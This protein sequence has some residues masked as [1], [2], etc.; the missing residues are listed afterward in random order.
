MPLPT[1]PTWNLADFNAATIGS[2]LALDGTLVSI[3]P[4]AF[5]YFSYNALYTEVRVASSDGVLATLDITTPVPAQYTVEIT[6]RFRDMPHNFGDLERRRIGLTVADDDGRGISIYFSKSGV[7]VARIDDFGSV[8]A[9][10]DTADTT[11]EISSAFRTIRIAVDSGIGRAYVFIGDDTGVPPQVRFVLPVAATPPS[12]VDT[13]QLFAKGTLTESSV[14]EIKSIKLAAGLVLPAIPPVASAGSDRVTVIGQAAR[15]D[16][17][18]SFDTDG[19]ALSYLW[20]LVDAPG[21]S[22]AVKESGSASTVDDGDGNGLTDVITVPPAVLPSWL[23]AGDVIQFA[24]MRGIVDTFDTLTGAITATSAVFPDDR[25]AEPIRFI[26]QLI[27]N[28]TT[29][30]PYIV[31]DVPGLYRAELVVNDG[32]SDSEASEVVVSAVGARAPFGIEPDVSPLWKALGSEWSMVENRELFQEVWTGIAQ[33]MAAKLLEAWQYNYNFSIRDAQRIFQRKWVAFRTML[34]EPA[35]ET[36][37]FSI[38]YGRIESSVEFDVA[39]PVVTG[40]TLSLSVWDG[41]TAVTD[42]EVSLSGSTLAAI[43]TAI[44]TVTAAHGV[45]AYA[46]APRIESGLALFETTASTVDDGDGDGYTA[47]LSVTPLSL[48][49]WVGAGDVLNIDGTH[50]TI[51]AVNNGT[52]TITLTAEVASDSL[53]AAT[54]IIHRVCRLALRSTTRGFYVRAS[55]GAAVLGMPA[56]TYNYLSGSTGALVTDRTYYVGG[57]VNLADAGVQSGDLLILNGGQAFEIDRILSSPQD[58]LPNQ[59][60]LLVDALP[61][62]ATPEWSIPSVVRS[63]ELDFD[64][65]GTYPGD[66]LKAEAF[67]SVSGTTADL[68][69][70]VVGQKLGQLAVNFNSYYAIAGQITAGVAWDVMILGVK[71]RKAIP[72]PEDVVGIPRLQD[73]I[74]LSANPTIYSEVIDYVLEP[75]YRDTDAAPIPMLQFRDAVWIDTDLEPPDVLWAELVLFSNERN[76]E[77][78]FG[79]LVGFMRDDA[80]VYPKDFNYVAGVAGLLYAQQRGPAVDPVQIGA[81]ILLGQAFAEA[82]GTIEEIRNDFSPTHGRIIIRDADGTAVSSSET[83]RTYYYRKI[84]NDTSATSGLALNDET[85][86]PWAVGDAIPQFAPIGAGVDVVD[87]KV[88]PA[89]YVPYV[90]SGAIN[91]LEK[92]HHFL[93]TFNLDV[94]EL[95]NITLL[96]QFVNR[97]KPKYTKPLLVGLRDHEEDIDVTDDLVEDVVMELFDSPCG[98][99]LAYMYDDYRGDGTI[100]SEHDDGVTFYDA[101]VDCP[102]DLIS[103]LIELDWAGGVPTYDAGFIAD[104]PITDV[105]GAHTGI[106]G[107]TFFLLYDTTVA[108]GTYTM[109]L[110]IK[111]GGVVLP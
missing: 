42:V 81:Q 51:S 74:P 13:F 98:S 63:E 101:R 70:V 21:G 64:L 88:D 50:A 43:V 102:T 76:V 93:I 31:P 104:I 32:V 109:T 6:A 44:N 95:A 103:F 61:A 4:S 73:V 9:L 17:R 26:R 67:D 37:T 18:A 22:A 14:I 86:A 107:S 65:E 39:V 77:N 62:D 19:A 12:V 7:A 68:T 34:A 20:R 35:R 57:G 60:V 90:R 91:E 83:V 33:M 69:G 16:G 10:E 92:F 38:R 23:A 41:G 53:T 66:L 46:Y 27:V 24:N 87:L 100:W 110:V 48:P 54:L 94:V 55:T 28:A 96:S 79:Q 97:A 52:G 82:A 11:E 105:T 85:S 2:L 71:R 45:Q 72:L 84:E 56:L 25:T 58:P 15:L 1:T 78:T 80:S 111:S 108:A 75:F 3:Q 29:E 5:P 40:T 106:P 30:T 89:W 8:T 59:R 47:T 99:P 49:S 36:A